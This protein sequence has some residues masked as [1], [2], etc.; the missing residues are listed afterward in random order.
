MNHLKNAALTYAAK[1][2][3]IFPCRRDK[4][5]ITI[6]GCLDATTN[7]EIIE[8]WWTKH[9]DANIGLNA[10]DAGFAVIDIDPGF[11]KGSIDY[12]ELPDTH[13]IAATPRGGLHQFY[14]LNEGEVVS[15]SSSKIAPHADVRSFNSYVLLAP[16][17]TYNG[18]YSWVIED[19]AGLRSD[20]FLRVANSHREKNPER[21]NWVIEP[22]LPENI[23]AAIKWLSQD[24]K[25]SV[26]GEGG[27]AT[28]YATAA[29]LRSYGLSEALAYDLMVEH[30]NPRN[31]PPWN[32]DELDHLQDKVAHGYAY[33]TSPPGNIT[34][35]Y[36]SAKRQAL[37]TNQLTHKKLEHDDSS[38]VW[39]L[40]RF[41]IRNRAAINHIPDPRWI[42]EGLI[43]AD[44]Y[45]ILYAPETQ[46]KTFIALDLALSIA[47]GFPQG[48]T[49]FGEADIV[50]PGPVLYMSG[51]GLG[52]FKKRIKGWESI[53]NN[54]N[55]VKD[56]DLFD[57]PPKLM[58][59]LDNICEFIKTARQNYQLIVID[60]LTR[61]MQGINESAQENASAFTG[62]VD[63][64]RQVGPDT[65]VLALHHT[66]KDG[67]LRGS[68]VFSGDAD[69]VLCMGERNILKENTYSTTLDIVKMKDA[70]DQQK[71]FDYVLEQVTVGDG[72][73]LIAKKREVSATPQTVSRDT[74]R[75]SSNSK[76][77][78]RHAN[79][80]T[81]SKRRTDYAERR[82]MIETQAIK[83]LCSIAGK[84]WSV[85][86][87]ATA[88]S[89]SLNRVSTSNAR[90]HLNHMKT[91]HESALH[92]HYDPVANRFK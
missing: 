58:D 13:L 75:K 29:H 10:G 85:G 15:P 7:P 11:E 61:V 8:T 24:A 23:T 86:A 78:P 77:K 66:N 9:P 28:A 25:I 51:E 16:S 6:N 46:F 70:S 37:F 88:I 89:H 17:E 63:A 68:S 57:P 50:Q 76:Q 53:H 43:P 54:G 21:D 49:Q 83:T 1:G 20:E 69:V 14:R 84:S 47:L 80:F 72:H 67:G 33:A 12:L 71:P 34:P 42:V 81:D 35:A 64:L 32:A 39:E 90:D 4:A 19:K 27:D 59:N 26:E 65:S 56:F 48:L 5:P 62:M 92:E 87:L 82:V 30:W 55:E 31:I 74:V 44:S 91:D 18:K 3:P 52:S 2:W 45:C 60:T 22:D 41:R 40:G 79:L 38:E 73:T 36:T